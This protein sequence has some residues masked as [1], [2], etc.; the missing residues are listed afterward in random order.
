MSEIIAVVNQKGGVGKTTTALN[1]SVSL[2][3][4]A[5]ETLAIDLDSQSNLTSGIGFSD[6]SHYD[7]SDTLL[8]SSLVFS[9]LAPTKIE[10]LDLLPSSSNL[11]G[12]ELMLKDLDNRERRLGAAL[13]PLASMYK[14]VLIDCPPSLGLLTV[15]ALSAANYVLIPMLP[16][17]YA[18]EG[19]SMLTQTIQRV[20]ETL[21]PDLKILGIVFTMF[22]PRL[23]LTQAVIKEVRE[24]FPGLTWDSV[25]PRNVRLAEAPS[26]SMPIHLYAPKSPGAQAYMDMGKEL[27]VR[28]QNREAS[29]ASNILST[30]IEKQESKEQAP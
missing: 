13:S 5:Q 9:A 21:N 7:V 25:V 8:D 10:F 3:Y 15:N 26:F 16:E 23:Q 20:K 29:P 1:L 12:I 2:A 19:L 11:I 22:D 17:Y 27:L 28:I 30:K 4:L 6:P 18:L 24:F 14:Y